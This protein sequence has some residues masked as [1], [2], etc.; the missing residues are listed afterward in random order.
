MSRQIIVNS[1]I[2][3]KRAAIL[4]NNSLEDVFFEQD[5]YEQIAGNIY[6]GRVKDVLPGM[7][8]A[9]IDIG[10]ERNAFLHINDLYPLL[11]KKQVKQW[12]DN[13]LGIHQVLQPGQEIMIQIIKESIGSKGP[14]A[15]CKISIPGRYFVL[16]PHEQR[17]N[18]SRKITDNKERERLK[19]ITAKLTENDYGIIIRTNARERVKEDLEL[20]L[21]YLI[22]IWKD[23]KETYRRRKATSL[24]YHHAGLIRQI[25]RDYMSAEVDKV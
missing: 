14:K 13:K 8:A 15:T 25:V 11:N 9:F 5:T 22:H 6:R 24:V 12:Q 3:E 7:Q 18:I 16:L 19:K 10:H 4:E 23:I 2:R 17:I 1:G 20:D 21:D